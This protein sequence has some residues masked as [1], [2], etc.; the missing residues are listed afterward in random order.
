MTDRTTSIRGL[1]LETRTAT[2]LDT[3]RYRPP[4]AMQE[5]VR[6]RD[7]TCA[8]PGCRV[9]AARCDLDH[10]VPYD[11][12]H[13]DGRGGAGRTRGAN[14]RPC[15]RRHHRLKTLTDWTTSL[16]PDPDGGETSV[17]VWTSPSGHRWWVRAPEL[18]PPPWDRSPDTDPDT[19]DDRLAELRALAA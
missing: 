2:H 9:P 13:P 10:V 12:G 7:L 17:V 14:L 4:A 1:V 16:A 5:L 18:E 19:A 6:S 8:A 11:H 3:H 15:C